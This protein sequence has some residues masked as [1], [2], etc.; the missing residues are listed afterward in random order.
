M[1]E[2]KN[3]KRER[4]VCLKRC[5]VVFTSGTKGFRIPA[6]IINESGYGMLLEID[7]AM[8]ANEDLVKIIVKKNPA[9][10]CFNFN[11]EVFTGMVRWCKAQND[12]IS[13]MYHVNIE[14]VNLNHR[15]NNV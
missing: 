3:R 8:N 4:L 14:I 1:S 12:C 10:G 9:N 6:R 2:N 11:E 13:R 15:E 7:Y 5:E